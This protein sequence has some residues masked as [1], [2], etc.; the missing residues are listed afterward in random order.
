VTRRRL[1]IFVFIVALGVFY[2]TAGP[3]RP[4]A[5]PSGTFS[6]GVLGDAPYYPWEEMKYRLV[7]QDLRAHD[8]QLVLHVGDIFWQPCTDARYQRSVDW[9]NA[10]PHPVIYTPGDNEWADCWTSAAG[11][12]VPLERLARLRQL[13][14]PA[15]TSLGGRRIAVVAQNRQAPFTEFV[16][17][18]RWAHAGLVFATV[19]LV[20]SGNAAQTFPGRTLHD[21][22][23]IV[24]RTAAA[25]A[26]LRET[27]ADAA[28]TGAH[29]VV[30]GFHA[31]PGFERS[32]DDP[33]RQR[34]EPFLT[35]LEEETERF[36]K[37]VLV[38]Q[39]DDHIYTVDRPLIRR[40][41]GR[42]LE[43]VTRVQVPGSPS[44]GW[45]RVVVT[46]GVQPS[47]TFE[48]RVVPRWKYW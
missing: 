48:P 26:W 39:G 20:G 17:N 33:E 30:I 18:V 43:N 2:M 29:A 36:G 23:A 13:F 32:A 47:F 3:P 31:N 24:R 42:A 16:E 6:F 28:A 38:A 10:L 4:A 11:E 7:L 15:N 5:A 37:P 19:H 35:A 14:Y 41:T 34:Y 9:F 27:F 8:L 46:P 12:F 45:V 21:D 44:V 22:E 25:T 1:T 40:T